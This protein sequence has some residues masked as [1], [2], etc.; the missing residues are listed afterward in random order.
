MRI[1]VVPIIA[2]MCSTVLAHPAHPHTHPAPPDRSHIYDQAFAGGFGCFSHRG[3]RKSFCGPALNYTQALWGITSASGNA[4]LRI[5]GRG[6]MI[7]GQS[8]DFNLSTNLRSVHMNASVLASVNLMWLPLG[9]LA[10]GS[11]LGV[12]YTLGYQSGRRTVLFGGLAVQGGHGFRWKDNYFGYQ[13]FVTTNVVH[14]PAYDSPPYTTSEY[15]VS[16]FSLALLFKYSR[17]F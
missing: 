1:A 11:E 17:S 13:L 2:M 12:G 15:D 10:I 14:D 8:G 4:S 7:L 5:D 16:P 9:D 3:Y 6:D